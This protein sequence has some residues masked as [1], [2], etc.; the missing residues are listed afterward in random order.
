MVISFAT[1][2]PGLESSIVHITG[3]NPFAGLLM[4][5]QDGS[6][7]AGTGTAREQGNPELWD[8][9]KVEQEWSQVRWNWKGL[10]DSV[11]QGN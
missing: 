10:M 11:G 2:G 3:E 1:G 7:T 6:T 5:G 4:C 9:M 8:S